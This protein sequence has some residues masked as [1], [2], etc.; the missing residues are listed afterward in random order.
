MHRPG[1][2]ESKK[3]TGNKLFS[4]QDIIIIVGKGNGQLT[5]MMP[6]IE[7]L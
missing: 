5:K 6:S 1:Q 7:Q 3:G 2:Y 4:C